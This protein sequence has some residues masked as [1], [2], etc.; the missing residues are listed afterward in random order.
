MTVDRA[1]LTAPRNGPVAPVTATIAP[2]IPQQTDL[3]VQPTDPGQRPRTPAARPPATRATIVHR[4]P[5]LLRATARELARGCR[6]ST[7]AIAATAPKAA[8]HRKTG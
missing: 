4:G 7:P 2:A 1:D 6:V 8:R 5:R 3:A